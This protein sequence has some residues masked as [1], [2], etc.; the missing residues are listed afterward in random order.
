LGNLPYELDP[1]LVWEAPAEEHYVAAE[2]RLKPRDRKPYQR[3]KT[4]LPSLRTW[5]YSDVVLEPAGKRYMLIL[6]FRYRNFIIIEI[7]ITY[8]LMLS[9]HRAVRSSLK[10]RR[11]GRHVATRTSLG[12]YLESISLRLSI[13]LAV[14]A[15]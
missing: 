14:V 5:P 3:G 9:F 6:A 11:G 12:G 15:T 7:F 1:S 2:E 13:S 4:R 8:I 10:N